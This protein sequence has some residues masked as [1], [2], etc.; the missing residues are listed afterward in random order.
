VPPFA[1]KGSECH[2]MVAELNSWDTACL[3]RSFRKSSSLW[4]WVISI[5]IGQNPATAGFCEGAPPEWQV[6]E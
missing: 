2:R 1:A 6:S 3:R 5:V 4:R